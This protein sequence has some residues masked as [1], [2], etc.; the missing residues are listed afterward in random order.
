MVDKVKVS[1][2]PSRS[3]I[4]RARVRYGLVAARK[5]RRQDYKRW[6]W[7]EPTELW[8]LDVTGSGVPGRSNRCS[9][10]RQGGFACGKDD[11]S[12]A[13]RAVFAVPVTTA[14]ASR[15]RVFCVR[16]GAYRG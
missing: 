6:Q 1:S 16:H 15:A 14:A 2:P 9:P 3:T 13:E 12:L 8:Q 4:Y 7:E 11:A 5:R 10:L